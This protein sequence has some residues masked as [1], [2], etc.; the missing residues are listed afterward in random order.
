[1]TYTDHLLEKVLLDL[2]YTKS[3]ITNTAQRDKIEDAII[4]IETVISERTPF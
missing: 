2:K 4:I 3:E 1:M